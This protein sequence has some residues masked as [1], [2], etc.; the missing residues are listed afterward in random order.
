MLTHTEVDPAYEGQGVGGAL[1]RA[2]MDDVRARQVTALVI[3]P[4][5]LSWIRRHREYTDLLYG[6]P[7]SRVTD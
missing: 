7:P 1:A 2:A 5:I 6:A 4:F 3:C